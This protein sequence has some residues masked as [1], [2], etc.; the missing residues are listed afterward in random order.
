MRKEALRAYEEGY[1]AGLCHAQAMLW[2]E[3]PL[4]QTRNETALAS[5]LNSD[6]YHEGFNDGVKDGAEVI[7]KVRRYTL[8]PRRAYA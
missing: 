5:L 7:S 1:R 6:A 4:C 2:P 3:A 8:L